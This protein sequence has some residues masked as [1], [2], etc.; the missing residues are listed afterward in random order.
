MMGILNWYIYS[1]EDN[2][3]SNGSNSDWYYIEVGDGK[4]VEE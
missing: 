1:R 4:N 3:M 2:E